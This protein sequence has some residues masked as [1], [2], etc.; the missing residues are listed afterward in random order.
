LLKIFAS[1]FMRNKG[2]SFSFLVTS[3]VLVCCLASQ[4]ILR[5]ISSI[6][7]FW[8]CRECNFFITNKSNWWNYLGLVFSVLDCYYWF[9][10]FS[11][12]RLIRMSTSSCLSFTILFLSSNWHISSRLSK[13]C[14]KS[15][16]YNP[17]IFL[18]MFM[19]VEVLSPLC[20]WY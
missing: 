16:P 11:W 1:V 15:W 9:N 14:V 5:S 3:L 4:D 13:L 19:W 20:F 7:V 10:Y 12:C 2:L 8:V 18:L 6:T 17:F